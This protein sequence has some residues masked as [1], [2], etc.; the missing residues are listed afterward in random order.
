[1]GL[2]RGDA[3]AGHGAG[4]GPSRRDSVVTGLP[5][6]QGWEE[7]RGGA[8]TAGGG[9]SVGVAAALVRTV[10]TRTGP[11]LV[12]GA[13]AFPQADFLCLRR[14]GTP[15]EGQVGVAG[16]SRPCLGCLC[17]SP[18][19]SEEVSLP[20][21]LCARETW[22]WGVRPRRPGFSA[23]QMPGAGGSFGGGVSSRSKPRGQPG[24]AVPSGP[25]DAREGVA[26]TAASSGSAPPGARAA[27]RAGPEAPLA[28]EEELPGP[29]LRLWPC[30]SRRLHPLGRGSFLIL[31]VSSFPGAGSPCPFLPAFPSFSPAAF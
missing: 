11:A 15:S 20:L 12:L 10:C 31:F 27:A 5:G 4:R 19:V 28:R 13:T 2:G 22:V 3:G 1:M 9:T 14:P 23:G 6:K 21:G 26:V 18:S 17:P 7:A 29:G 8:S 30:P 16:R 25:R 24:K